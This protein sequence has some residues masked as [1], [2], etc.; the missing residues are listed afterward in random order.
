MGSRAAA[1]VL[2][3]CLPSGA[4][5]QVPEPGEPAARFVAQVS[6]AFF[7]LLP[8]EN[9]AQARAFFEPELAEMLTPAAWETTRERLLAEAGTIPRYRAHGLSFYPQAEVLLAAFTRR[10]TSND[11]CSIFDHLRLSRL[12]DAGRGSNRAYADRAIRGTPRHH[13]ADG[14]RGRGADPSVLALPAR[15]DRGHFGSFQSAVRPL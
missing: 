9:H 10:N 13:A 8:T 2:S 5:A 11:I 6:E 7:D 4:L 1:L 14:A 3:L 15:C 12:V